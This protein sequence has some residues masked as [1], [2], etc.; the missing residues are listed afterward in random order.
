[1]RKGFKFSFFSAIQLLNIYLLV[2]I[3]IYQLTK[4]SVFSNFIIKKKTQ[5]LL[6]LKNFLSAVL[7]K[8]KKN[9]SYSTLVCLFFK[10]IYQI[11]M[12]VI[13]TC[14][15][16]S[17]QDKDYNTVHDRHRKVLQNKRDIRQTGPARE[18]NPLSYPQQSDRISVL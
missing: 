12:L 13:Q 15:Q 6:G 10:H 18:S 3:F 14:L 4:F 11:C 17:R 8:L 2:R 5:L 7:I 16:I 9:K 1:M